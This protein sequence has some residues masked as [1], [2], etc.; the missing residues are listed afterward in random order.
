MLGAMRPTTTAVALAGA[1][2]AASGAYALGTQVDDGSASAT[3]Q[4]PATQQPAAAGQ[5]TASDR[6]GAHGGGPRRLASRLGVTEARLRAA[7]DAVRPQRGDR[8]DRDA[9][10]ARL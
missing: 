7:L 5:A 8:P 2:A 10:A 1:V 9:L 3:Q 6:R 4:A